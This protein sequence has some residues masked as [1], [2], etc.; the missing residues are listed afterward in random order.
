MQ[1]DTID[2]TRR[3]VWLAALVWAALTVVYAIGYVSTLG[4]WGGELILVIIGFLALAGLPAA[5]VWA[6]LVIGANSAPDPTLEVRLKALEQ[7]FD[8]QDRRLRQIEAEARKHALPAPPPAPAPQPV[9]EVADVVPPAEPASIRE[10]EPEAQAVLPLDGGADVE[11]LTL[12]DTI[13]ALNF[14]QDANDRA[15]FAVLA[16]ALASH[17]LAR[18]LQASEDCLNLLA[19]L[20]LYMDDLLLAPATAQDWRQFARGGRARADLMPLNGINDPA[21]ITSVREALRTDPI[22]RDAA[23][24]FQ[25]KFDQMLGQVAPEA[26]DEAL[27]GLL[28]TRSGR[29]FVLLV[30]VSS[31]GHDAPRVRDNRT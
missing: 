10:P 20:G 2:R 21:A 17:E 7:K 13:L 3:T 19:H 25:R 24:H 6:L 5:L 14:P 1:P 18:L 9:V 4:P 30:Q 31:M 11:P 27:L 16:R 26:G 8:A 28:D 29:A 22:F 12:A 15:G 23:L